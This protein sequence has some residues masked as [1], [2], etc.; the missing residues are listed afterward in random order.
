MYKVVFSLLVLVFGCSLREK[1]LGVNDDFKTD[2]DIIPSFGSPEFSKSYVFSSIDGRQGHHAASVVAF[3]DNKLLCAWY[4]YNDSNNELAS[5]SIYLSYYDGRWSEPRLLLS[6]PPAKGNPVL[7]AEGSRVWLFYASVQ[8]GWSTAQVKFILSDDEGRTWSSPFDFPGSP[9][10]NVKNPPIRVQDSDLL[11]PAY[12]DMLGHSLFYKSN[13]GKNWKLVSRLKA[14]SKNIQPSVFTFNEKIV[15]L[16]RSDARMLLVSKSVDGGKT[17]SLPS[18]S[19]F[20][21]P[22]SN[23]IVGKLKSGNVLLVFN[24]SEVA[25]NPLSATISRDG[26]ATWTRVKNIADEDLNYSYPSFAQTE[27]SVI[28]LVYSENRDHIVHVKFNESWVTN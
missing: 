3:A 20:P 13:D 12:D 16:M 6:S 15:A 10:T 22:N 9:G 7:Y 27:D 25:R 24:N 17:W 8:L 28:H 26:G 23:S 5:S 21:N 1:N 4:S 18:N 14:Q 11:L 2:V 19:G